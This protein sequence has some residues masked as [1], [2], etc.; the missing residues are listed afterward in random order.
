[1]IWVTNFS[2]ICTERTFHLHCSLLVGQAADFGAPGL[3][4][5]QEIL[6]LKPEAAEQNFHIKQVCGNVSQTQH[7]GAG[8]SRMGTEG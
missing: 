4:A 3:F 6:C 8:D 5:H 7:G 1:M 2:G